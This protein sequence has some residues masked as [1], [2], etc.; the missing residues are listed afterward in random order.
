MTGDASAFERIGRRGELRVSSLRADGTHSRF[1]PIWS[2]MVDGRLFVRSYMGTEGRWYRGAMARRAGRVSS[3][4]DTIDVAFAPAPADLAD[5]I[6]GAY[7]E[8]YAG[9][10]YL[11]PMLSA[12]ARAS[13]LELTARNA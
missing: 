4:P 6:D 3:G 8:K 11:A 10:A 13:A 5:R 1:V 7:R 9:S 2:V 12:D